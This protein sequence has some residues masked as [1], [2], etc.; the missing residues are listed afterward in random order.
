MQENYT[1]TGDEELSPSGK[2]RIP[3]LYQE[4]PAW[5]YGA[6][7]K[8]SIRNSSGHWLSRADGAMAITSE[9]ANDMRSLRLQYA[10]EAALVGALEAAEEKGSVTLADPTEA[11][12]AMTKARA[13]VA[14][15][16]Q[17]RGGNAA[18]EL[19][20]K[21]A[22]WLATR[23]ESS[24]TPA[25]MMTADGIAA[26]VQAVQREQERRSGDVVVVDVGSGRAG[27]GEQRESEE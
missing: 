15:D 24:E 13:L 20:G 3:V 2:K 17:A 14:L 25:L 23:N 12:Q 22:G 26:L 19:V 27:S 18:Y 5:L 9:N 16:T 4:K 10:R 7:G 1:V 6:P 11:W 8:Q 21:A